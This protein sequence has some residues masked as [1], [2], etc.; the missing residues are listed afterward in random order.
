ML[1][2]HA[3]HLKLQSAN[4]EISSRFPEHAGEGIRENLKIE[5][6]SRVDLPLGGEPFIKRFRYVFLSE[7]TKSE[8]DRKII[9][10]TVTR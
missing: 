2:T 1:R 8:T 4:N 10:K 9:L 7:P 3:I 5:L 6:K